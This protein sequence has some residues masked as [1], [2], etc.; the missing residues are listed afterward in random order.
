MHG[1][2][3]HAFMTHSTA[4]SAKLAFKDAAFCHTI[5]TVLRARIALLLP[6]AATG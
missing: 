1:T 3:S 4:R 5:N 2:F 6:T